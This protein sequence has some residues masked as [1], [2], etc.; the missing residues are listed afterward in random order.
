MHREFISVIEHYEPPFLYTSWFS[1]CP[2]SQHIFLCFLSFHFEVQKTLVT[3][4]LFC[5]VFYIPN[6]LEG[7][8]IWTRKMY[9]F[10]NMPYCL[11][12]VGRF[13]CLVCFLFLTVFVWRYLYTSRMEFAT[14]R[15]IFL[16]FPSLLGSI[17]H[18]FEALNTLDYQFSL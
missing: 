12:S 15:S 2:W 13:L 9:N 4:A 1:V 11:S 14:T 18:M 16:R 10:I 17:S 5:F 8:R 3:F 6:W 7:N